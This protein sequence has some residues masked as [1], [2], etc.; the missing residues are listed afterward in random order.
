MLAK[1]KFFLFASVALSLS[2]LARRPS[3]Y[4]NLNL[5]CVI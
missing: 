2:P 1:V 3:V 4:A 5:R